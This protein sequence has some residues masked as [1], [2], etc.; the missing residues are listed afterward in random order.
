MLANT[1]GREKPEF[2][3]TPP[4]DIAEANDVIMYPRNLVHRPNQYR[5]RTEE[6]DV[7][8]PVPH[9]VLS[10]SQNYS[11]FQK[12]QNETVENKPVDEDSKPQS[13][14]LVS[15]KLSEVR[16]QMADFMKTLDDFNERSRLAREAVIKDYNAAV[17]V[18]QEIVKK[19]ME[20]NEQSIEE[21]R[22]RWDTKINEQR[23]PRE[24]NES[25]MRKHFEDMG[26]IFEEEDDYPED[27]KRNI[28]QSEEK[29]LE[30]KSVSVL[31]EMMNTKDN[32]S[33]EENMC[34]STKIKTNDNSGDVADVEEEKIDENK[35]ESFGEEGIILIDS[36]SYEEYLTT[37]ED[38]DDDV[39]IPNKNISIDYYELAKR[40][41]ETESEETERN[42]LEKSNDSCDEFF[43]TN[44]EDSAEY[45]ERT[46]IDNEGLDDVQVEESF[47]YE[48]F[49]GSLKNKT[50]DEKEEG[51]DEHVTAI[52]DDIK[53]KGQDNGGQE[54][55][56]NT[57]RPI[58]RRNVSCSLEMQLAKGT[59]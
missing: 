44:E 32:I 58:V 41:P 11:V 49:I 51:E 48:K 5:N 43:T 53:L 20:K 59:D 42:N 39:M 23:K 8:Q 12:H 2:E 55:K 26:V 56:E 4:A 6:D 25:E 15:S 37:N 18:E 29:T 35:S 14:L 1:T 24:I 40:I 3:V 47:N 31:E 45:N 46:T 17:E 22:M 21:K 28:N 7:K 52:N 19:I 16:A 34:E 36:E 38:E 54:Q 50:N 13:S 10:M 57:E 33:Y 27:I 30:D 9:K